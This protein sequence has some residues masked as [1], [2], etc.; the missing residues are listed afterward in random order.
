M[1]KFIFIILSILLFS[2]FIFAATPN[3]NLWQDKIFEVTIKLPNPYY[4]VIVSDYSNIANPNSVYES[5]IRALAVSSSKIA[6][7]AVT[8][9]KLADNAVTN[10]KLA[11]ASVDTRK[12]QIDGVLTENIKD[13]SVTAFKI[14]NSAVINSKIADGAVTKEKIAVKSV[15]HARLEVHPLDKCPANGA[16]IIYRNNRL[17]WSN[18]MDCSSTMGISGY[19]ESRRSTI[20]FA[21]PFNQCIQSVTHTVTGTSCSGSP[22]LE[23]WSIFR[24][25]GSDSNAQTVNNISGNRTFTFNAA[26]NNL[27][28]LSYDVKYK[29]S[30]SATG[31]SA[32]KIRL[33]FNQVPTTGCQP[34]VGANM[35]ET[36][37][38][39]SYILRVTGNNCIGSCNY[40]INLNGT[41]IDQG[42][43]SGNGNIIETIVS[44]AMLNT[45]QNTWIVTIRYPQNSPF[46]ELTGTSSKT[47]TV[48][49]PPSP[50]C[51]T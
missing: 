5:S 14:A 37:E 49:S 10:S 2:G 16:T 33:G 45:G 39:C 18:S 21:S 30:Q 36:L 41:T 32:E 8:Y 15:D 17:E 48:S 34:Q 50:N 6:N 27:Y 42:S 25:G 24:S 19:I 7:N 11:D 9:S 51:A 23:E 35:T 3:N 29:L 40:T 46:G 38:E 12:I 22:C 1:K 20:N 47:F 4:G 43:F 28:K 31:L 13:Y 44:V 26:S